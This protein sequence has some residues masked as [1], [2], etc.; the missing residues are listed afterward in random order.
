MVPVR[1]LLLPISAAE[2]P[3]TLYVYFRADK[4]KQFRYF[5][6]STDKYSCEYHVFER[7]GGER[8][9]RTRAFS[10]T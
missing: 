7:Y 1:E 6:E 5:I 4:E 3:N 2:D 9:Y 8:E 10:N